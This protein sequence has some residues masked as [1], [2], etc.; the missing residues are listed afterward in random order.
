MASIVLSTV[1]ASAG[2]ALGGSVGAWIG[3]RL[4]QYAGGMVD[5]R[6]FGGSRTLTREGPR[7]K[8]L[9]VQTSTYGA[10][11]PVLYGT[12]RLAGNILWA[13]PIKETAVTSTRSSGGGKGGGGGRVTESTTTYSYSVTL[14]IALCEGAVDGLGRVWADAKLLDTSQGVWRLHRGTEDQLPD[15]LIESIEGMGNT[16]AYRGLAYVVIEDFPLADFGNRIPN[17]TFE[18][19]RKVKFADFGAQ[20][21]EDRIQSV[22]L[23]PG[24]GEFVYDTLPH[25]KVSGEMA[26]GQWAQAGMRE[27]INL[28]NPEGKANSLL[29]LDQMQ[30]TLPNLEWVGVVVTWFG[31]SLDAASCTILPGVEYKEGATTEPTVWNSAGFTRATA[32]QIT[33]VNGTPRYGGTP[34]D[35]SLVRLLTELR[36]RGYKIML[37]PMFFMDVE[38]K[39]WRGRV[40]GSASAVDNFFTKTNGYNAFITHYATL[41]AGKVD[42]FVIGS[43]LIG[44]TKVA[45]S[46]GVYP[47]VNRLINLAAS[48]RAILGGGVK[49]T[50]AAD[51]SEYHHTDGG[52]YNLDPLWA[53]PNID[54]VGIDAYFPLTDSP[55]RGY[56]FE[57]AKQGW[58]SG[59]GYDW[60][61]TDGART[62]K[63]PLAAPYA[64]KN[65]G[66]WWGNAHT[67]PDGNPTPWVPESKPVWFTEYGFPSVDSAIN[68]PNVFYDPDSVEGFFPRFS[69]GRPDVL[70]QRLGLAATEEVWKDSPIV[71]HRFV[72]TWDARPFPYWPDLRQV[73]ADGGQW[74]TGHWVQGKLG[75]S[76]LGAIVLDLCRRSGLASAEVDVTRLI[77]RVEGMVLTEPVTARQAIEMLQDAYFF[78]AVETEGQVK[79]VPHGQE[80]LATLPE[81]QLIAEGQEVQSEPV[82]LLRQQ[83]LE[84]PQRVHVTYLNRMADYQ[85]GSY[86]A[87]RQATV[88]RELVRLDLPIILTE[89]QAQQVAETRLYRDWMERLS[90]R[91]AL[92]PRYAAYEPADVLTLSLRGAEHRVKITRAYLRPSGL[93]EVEAVAEEGSIYDPSPAVRP[94]APEVAAPVPPV[95][96]RL[97]LLDLPALPEDDPFTPRLHVAL[98]P[99]DRGWRGA[100]LYRS[101]DGG[102]SF[103]RVAGVEEAASFGVALTALPP[104]LPQVRDEVSTL[105]VALIGAAE[106]Q[107][108]GEAALLNGANAAQVG[109]EIIQFQEAEFLAPGK[110]RLKRLLRGRL[111]TE[112]AISGHMAGEAFTLLEGLVSEPASAILGLPRRYRAVAVGGSIGSATEEA[113]F[114]F[115]GL[116][117]KPLSPVHVTGSRNL[118]GDLTV[119]WVRRSRGGDLWRDATDVPLNEL[120]EAYEVE[121]LNGSAQVVRVL[122]GLS[123]PSA[124]YSAAQQVTDF[125]AVQA[126]VTLRVT[127]L[128]ATVGRGFPALATL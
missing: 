110:Y 97:R 38:G 3:S 114:T 102:E 22:I 2:S 116:G 30:E 35:E 48:V 65:I 61:Y 71:T 92:P 42:A 83:E 21:V 31:N 23:I 60:Y 1:G 93:L 24:S 29:A 72:W 77:Q 113:D 78:D 96:V 127:Q 27:R 8:D 10:M 55:Q 56:D 45:S 106:L 69:K 98:A 11:I 28:H 84:L 85:A 9:A 121:I 80:S 63:A 66:W 34:D 73:W 115:R 99:R 74:K 53:S 119:H 117:L 13:L 25:Y 36:N 82:S 103:S 41:G 128:S 90:F 40:T 95:E 37:Y 123:Q 51:W 126:S 57:V 14:A 87:Q 120:A 32:R 12:A 100:L 67:N 16:P 122:T 39:P 54:M 94:S 105:E 62:V 88:S 26:G 124:L 5:G 79:F 101:A 68:Q 49:I 18:V 20:P 6:L 81:E 112:H 4:G 46:P 109:E 19:R 76:G 17:F 107:S 15:P 125:G 118:S 47:A 104:A 108:I 75:M 52:W 70:A 7:L 58:I 44:L 86:L 43:E 59:E 50:Y 91:F 89:E 111:G 64:W 33:L